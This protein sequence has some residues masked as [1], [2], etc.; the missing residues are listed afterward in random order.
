MGHNHYFNL[1]LSLSFR[2]LSMLLLGSALGIQA[3][4]SREAAQTPIESTETNLPVLK[5]D[6]R[7]DVEGT[8][9]PYRYAFVTAGAEKYT[10]LIPEA[11]RVDTS[12][13]AKIKLASPDYSTMIVLGLARA[14]TGKGKPDPA[15][16]RN[17]VLIEHPDAVIN[18]EQALSAVGQMAPV[19]DFTWKTETGIA[20][21][22][23][24]F[25]VSVPGGLMEFNLTAS[26]DKFEIGL[27]Q[28]NLVVLTFRSGSN[29][30]FDYVVGSKY[31]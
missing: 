6:V 2:W 17:H 26:P 9:I 10:F 19:V 15:A 22:T 5:L 27:S 30:K 16:L 12:D 1:K 31:P 20:R 18:D 23:R 14:F 7:R 3:Q 11:C 21:K 8:Y 13:P 4:E 25:F 29:G 24:T 28:L